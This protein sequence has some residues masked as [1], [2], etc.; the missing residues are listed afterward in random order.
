[1][2]GIFT[3]NSFLIYYYLWFKNILNK[4]PSTILVYSFNKLILIGGWGNL[5]FKY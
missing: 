5:R 2:I 1:M 3:F 4:T